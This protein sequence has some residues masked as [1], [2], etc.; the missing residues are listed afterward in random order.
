[1]DHAVGR[2]FREDMELVPALQV[3]NPA[4]TLAQLFFRV[5]SLSER[6]VNPFSLF[7]S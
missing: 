1:M 2:H 7:S 4:W 3:V 6:V 5:A